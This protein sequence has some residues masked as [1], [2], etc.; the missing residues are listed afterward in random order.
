MH[1]TVRNRVCV[2]FLRLLR[3]AT[4]PVRTRLLCSGVT[5]FTGMIEHCT[6]H[7][8]VT[9]IVYAIWYRQGY[10]QH[11]RNAAGIMLMHKRPRFCCSV[12]DASEKGNSWGSL[13][14]LGRLEHHQLTCGVCGG[15]EPAPAMT[16]AAPGSMVCR[17]P[18]S[19][20]TPML[21]VSVLLARNK[22]T[23]SS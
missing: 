4:H 11:N 20:A 17:P 3:H 18:D 9:E 19:M 21:A 6:V 23:T 22:N 12:C 14:G 8:S 16:N 5:R 1:E 7:H 15:V 10:N 13:I 2:H